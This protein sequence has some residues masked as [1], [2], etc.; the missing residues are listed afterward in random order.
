MNVAAN[1]WHKVT[2]VTKLC[3]V[4]STTCRPS[5]WNLLNV[6]LL[7]PGILRWPLNFETNCRPLTKMVSTALEL[8]SLA[9][10]A[11]FHRNMLFPFLGYRSWRWRQCPPLN[12]QYLSTQLHITSHRIATLTEQSQISYRH[13]NDSLL[14]FTPYS[15]AR[16]SRRFEGAW[17][18]YLQS[19]WIWFRYRSLKQNH[20]STLRKNS[21]DHHLSNACLPQKNTCLTELIYIDWYKKCLKE[22]G[23]SR[24]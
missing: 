13:P 6:M 22:T 4:V 14:G 7:A 11:V 20:S 16:L 18:Y 5:V 9:G 8:C 12:H 1:P 24:G 3:V 19:D 10:K 2:Q 17:C 21:G 23:I 15:I